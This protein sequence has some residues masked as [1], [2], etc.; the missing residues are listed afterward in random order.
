MKSSKFYL[1]IILI[2]ALSAAFLLLFVFA[3]KSAEPKPGEP[4]GAV[5]SGGANPNVADPTIAATDP[6]HGDP[7][8]N[9]A[10]T[11]PPTPE[12]T[13][14]PPLPKREGFVTVRMEAGDV[15]TGKLLL[16][17]HDHRYEIPQS[18]G[19]VYINQERNDSYLVAD[20]KLTIASTVMKPLNDMMDAFRKETG[21]TNVAIT[22]A[23][24]S[25]EKQKSVYD[26]FV[27]RMGNDEAGKWASQPGFSE[28][29]T[30]LAID[31]GIL[32]DDIIGSFSDDGKYSWF[33]DN[34]Y[35][36]GFIVR[37]PPEKIG[38]TKVANEPWHLRYVGSPHATVIHENGWCFE[39]YIEFIEGFTPEDGYRTTCGGDAYEIYYTQDTDIFIPVGVEYAISGDNVYGFI[40]TLKV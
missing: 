28:H 6:T 3:D 36:Y 35:K 21:I 1:S 33:K 5:S 38:I 16:V 39:E 12:F 22:S 4:T 15:G 8:Q 10:S 40:V 37:Y 32:K 30:G 2:A 13:R 31:L 18:R 14:V 23:F 29:H 7:T 19:Y 34:S 17:N 26:D 20:T 25:Y 24:R 9:G 11:E 27:K